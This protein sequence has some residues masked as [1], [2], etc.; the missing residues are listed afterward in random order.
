[1]SVEQ[2][3]TSTNRIQEVIAGDL[4]DYTTKSGLYWMQYLYSFGI[5]G[6]NTPENA[7]YLGYINAKDLYPE[8]G[9]TS[10]VDFSKSY[11]MEMQKTYKP[12][13]RLL[14]FSAIDDN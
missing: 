11:L 1:M 4:T 3:L 2:I 6:D 5:R 14:N 13:L 7:N 8:L 12:S 9:M 10:Y